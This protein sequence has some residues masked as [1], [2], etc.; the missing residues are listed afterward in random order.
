MKLFDYIW[1]VLKHSTTLEK[2]KTFD[3]FVNVI[4]DVFICQKQ[5]P[6]LPFIHSR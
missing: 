4:F 3:L 6:S 1:R 5:M 2:S